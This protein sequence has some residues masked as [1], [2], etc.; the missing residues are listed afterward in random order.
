MKIPQT[1]RMMALQCIFLVFLFVGLV[2]HT[3]VSLSQVTFSTGNDFLKYCE[4]EK[5]ECNNYVAGML[6]GMNAITT[7]T[8]SKYKVM[9]GDQVVTVRQLKDVFVKY[10]QKYPEVRSE[11]TGVLFIQALMKAFPC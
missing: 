5:A 11:H 6:D 4:Y 10:L 7:H 3:K 2:F 8:K 9:C 1:T